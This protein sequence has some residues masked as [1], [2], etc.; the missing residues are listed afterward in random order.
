MKRIFSL[1]LVVML[2]V[3]A[4]PTAYATNDYTAGTAV[5]YTADDEANENWTITVPAKLAP[6]GS[7]TVTLQGTWPSNKTIS[8]TAEKTVTL[9]NNILATD[10]RVLD[11]TF[12]GIKEAGNDTAEKTYMEPVSVAA[13]E[14][15]L[16]GTWSG[17]FNYNVETETEAVINTPLKFGEKYI[18]TTDNTSG[19]PGYVGM[20][21][22]FYADGSITRESITGEITTFPAGT[23][24]YTT[25]SISD[26]TAAPSQD[27]RWT[28]SDDGVTLKLIVIG[29]P[30]GIPAL[31]E[32]LVFTLE[33]AI[34]TPNLISFTLVYTDANINET[35]QAEEGMTWAEWADS[36]YNQ[37]VYEYAPD[38][39]AQDAEVKFL[40]PKKM[41]KLKICHQESVIEDNVERANSIL[42]DGRTYVL[43]AEE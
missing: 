43:E 10:Q 39:I 36:E 18:C 6:G 24:T 33:S 25:N 20:Y 31:V 1:L 41:I 8:V 22:I 5:T 16:F 7:G 14:N 19:V 40:V 15:V 29:Y 34:P 30:D 37:F 17:K 27:G 3:S 4:V 38:R 32:A 23:A 21:Q 28:V 11:I 35:F 12:L 9:T 42:Q 26:S 2:L 13:I